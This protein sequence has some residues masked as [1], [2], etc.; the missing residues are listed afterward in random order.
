M[1]GLA[2]P[3][4]LS[5]TGQVA[6]P[7]INRTFPPTTS[8][9]DFN[10]PT[11]WT[12]TLAMNAYILVA[13]PQGV[14]NWILIGGEPGVLA[15][16]TGNSG[17]AVSPDSGNIYVVGDGTTI[18]IVGN[19][20][21]ST[22]TVSSGGSLASLY[23]EDSG[24]AVSSA[25]NLI[26]TGGS[27]GLTTLGSGHTVS[28]TGTLNVAHGGTGDTSLTAYAVMCGGTTST[29]PVQSIASVGT[30]G[31]VLTSNGAALLPTMQNASQ[32]GKNV[33]FALVANQESN[34]TGD[35]TN[36][37]IVFD[38]VNINTGGFDTTTGIFTSP[39]N[40]NYIINGAISLAGV[41]SSHIS[42][43][44]I[45][46]TSIG[47]FTVDRANY[48]AMRI[49]GVDSGA[50]SASFS[51]WANLTAG[52]TIS[53]VIQ[54]AGGTKVVSVEGINNTNAFSY[55]SIVRVS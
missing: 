49:A 35:G 40:A 39:N 42:G 30:S 17:G 51:A 36:Y 18:N 8:F 38:S 10:V 9:N 41:T 25:G 14:A 55:L 11:V 2:P 13:K 20:G 43:I 48:A 22:L 12:D 16:L 7:S 5:Y 50:Y 37:T 3:N 28:L 47:N 15:T 32:A 23:T 53:V 1:S 33:V 24:T 31:Q 45:V 4:S 6:V 19:P 52:Q 34:V 29:N 27:T 44:L 46:S 26:V 21:T 54:V